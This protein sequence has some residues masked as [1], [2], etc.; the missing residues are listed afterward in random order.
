MSN[1]CEPNGVD[2]SRILGCARA[3]ERGEVCAPRSGRMVYIS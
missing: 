3:E 2:V 1:N